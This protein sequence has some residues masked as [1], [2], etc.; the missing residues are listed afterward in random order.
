MHRTDAGIE[1][2]ATDLSQFLGC[3]HRTGLDLAVSE[4]GLEAPSWADPVLEILRER[5]LEHERSFV[6]ALTAQGLR[7]TDC[8]GLAGQASVDATLAAMQGGADAIVQAGLRSGRWFGRPDVLRR[9]ATPSSLGDWSYYPIDTKLAK[10]TTGGTVLQLSLY[11]EMLAEAQSHLPETFVVVTPHPQRPH[12]TF[13]VLDFAAYFR[14][15][16]RRLSDASALAAGDVIAGNYPEPVTACEVCRWRSRCDRKRHADD[17]L[18]LVAGTSRLQRR[19]LEANGVR[20]LT[21]L[22]ELTL[23]LPFKPSRGAQEGY[24][25]VHEQARVQLAGRALGKVVHELLP[26]SDEHGLA[27]LPEPSPG[28]MFIDFEGDPFAQEGGRE[29]LF[30]AIALDASGAAQSLSRWALRPGE[31]RSAFEALIDSITE[32]RAAHPGMHVYHYA[33]YEPAAIKRLMGRYGTRE[34]E[35]DTLLR[36]GVFVDLYAVVRN[37]IRASVE[38]YSIKELESLYSFARTRLL[39]EARTALRVVERAL[40]FRALDLVTPDIRAAVEEYNRDDCLSTHALRDW[41][42]R[43]RA[44]AVVAGAALPRPVPGDGA[45][46]EAIDAR[47]QRIAVLI[48]ALTHDIPDDPDLR[49]DEQRAQLLLANLLDYHRRESKAPWWEYFRL[50]DMPEEDLFDERMALAGL[51]FD[52]LQGGTAK[53]PIHRYRYPQQDTDLRDGD[54]LHLQD[55]ATLGEVVAV[56]RGERTIDV[57]KRGK[58]IDTHPRAVFAHKFI[59]PDVLADSIETI[60]NDVAQHGIA[61]GSRYRVAR[62]LLLARPPRVSTGSFEPQSGEDAVR[63]AVRVAPVLHETVLAIQGPPGTGKT[64]TGAEMICE[65]VRRGLKV[66]VTAVSH[67]VIRN[68]LDKTVE[69][70]GK[71]GPMVQCAHK[72]TELSDDAGAILE[73]KRSEDALAAIATR[74]AHVLGG[75]AWM[76]ALPI[77]TGAVDVLFVDE[78]GQMSLANVLAC[79][80]GAENVVLLGDPQQL[81][82]PQQGVHPEGADASSLQHMLAGRQTIAAGQGIFLPETWRMH[83]A[84]TSF[85]SEL[86]YEGRLLPRAGLGRQVLRGT[87]GF[88]GAGLWHVPVEH[89]GNQN[90]STEEV[91]AVEQVVER[92]L[93]AKATWTDAEGVERSLGPGDILVV[94]PYNAHVSLL[95]ERLDDRGIRVGTVDR[96]QG[97]EAPVVIYS[98]AT[99]RPEDAPRG[100]E[101]LYSLNRLNVATSRA[102]CACILVANPRLLEPECRSPQQMKLANALCRFAELA[103]PV[104]G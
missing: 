1:L 74:R 100:M 55:D 5:G 29:Y 90:S 52:S 46:P 34:A 64:F 68:L 58:Q 33:P 95:E 14:L 53:A 21:E 61:G 79:S 18:S 84:I 3:K 32:R 102:R 20:T 25:R 8:G 66:G 77:F 13:R 89:D 7:V 92:L 85:T 35:V 37:G 51:T 59:K 2:S 80:P 24:V 75:T 81:E 70:A 101:F 99:S 96:F 91:A 97:Q 88:D 27:R 12:Q 38:S 72:V 9:A 47:A 56:D 50:R 54:E 10:E 65:L 16:Q 76:W 26:P 98:T 19:E 42:E 63:F 30:G 62:E 104:V 6:H 82:Q 60:A 15:V 43:V 22:G 94:A 57:K 86:F 4:G 39:V 31:E 78:A 69:A 45:A 17:H 49:S 41:L 73:L 71:H 28:D 48:R 103:R 87:D 36:A 44:D 83:P 93:T 67:K 40:E 11:A 23:P